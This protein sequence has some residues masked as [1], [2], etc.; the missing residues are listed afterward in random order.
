MGEEVKPLKEVFKPVG[1]IETL[2]RKFYILKRELPEGFKPPVEYYVASVEFWENN[3]DKPYQEFRPALNRQ[4]IV[5][6]VSRTIF[7]LGGNV[8]EYYLADEDAKEVLEKLRHRTNGLLEEAVA[9]AEGSDT[10]E[11]NKVLRNID[12]VIYYAEF[13]KEM[14]APGI[15][16]GLGFPG[17]AYGVM[18]GVSR[19]QFGLGGELYIIF[20]EVH[21]YVEGYAV[22]R[23]K[24]PARFMLLKDSERFNKEVMEKIRGFYGGKRK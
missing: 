1:T 12:E 2:T 8:L 3:K 13:S 14:N 24:V 22:E 20:E 6:V 23:Y 4:M 7:F 10:P 19:P 17:T 5:R 9:L 21:S 16:Y 18:L 15:S 11:A